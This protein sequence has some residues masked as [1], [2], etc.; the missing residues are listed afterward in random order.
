ME[1]I[2]GIAVLLFLGALLGPW[3]WVIVG[4][5][6]GAFAIH[7]CLAESGVTDEERAERR[8][9]KEELEHE[10][11]MAEIRQRE[12]Q[13]QLRLQAEHE[14]SLRRSGI[15]SDVGC[16]AAKAGVAIAF[17]ALL[18]VHHRHRH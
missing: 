10:S 7:C 8:R 2:I 11:S 12:R 1:L 17:K 16:A 3:F 5:G 6:I 14:K 18:G 15:V 4:I 13:Q 9:R